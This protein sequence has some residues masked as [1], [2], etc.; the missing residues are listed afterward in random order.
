MSNFSVDLSPKRLCRYVFAAHLWDN[1]YK[2]FGSHIDV[3]LDTGSFNTAIHKSLVPGRGVL[4]N[5]TMKVSIG[6]YKGDA[7]ICV[8]HKLKIG[9]LELEKV[10][11]LAVPF[12]GELKDHILLGANVTNNWDFAV[13]RIRNRLDITE[14]F[15]ENTSMRKYPYRYC[16]DN[17]G[18]I[19]AFQ[20]FESDI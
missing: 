16:F 18:R 14:Q 3:L 2:K 20:S 12:D 7:D 5:Q 9:N 17:K 11:A 13:S 19:M 15:C 10:V 4:T 6:G 1:R 8:L